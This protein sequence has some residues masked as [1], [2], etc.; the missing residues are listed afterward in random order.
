VAT[1]CNV[2]GGSEM[3]CHRIRPNVRHIGILHLVSS[4]TISLQST[5]HSAPICKILSKSDHP[6]QK[7]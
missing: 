6:Q 4:L 5:C 3:T 7:K 2:A 1:P